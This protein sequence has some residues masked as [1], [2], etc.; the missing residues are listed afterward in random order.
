M[1]KGM[2]DKLKVYA[3]DAAMIFLATQFTVVAKADRNAKN[4][5]GV[6]ETMQ[7]CNLYSNS[8]KSTEMLIEKIEE[9]AKAAGISQEEKQILLKI[10]MAEAEGEGT[11]G[12]AY[13]MR[14]VLN[15][16][17]SEEFPNTIKKVVFQKN[18]F[19]PVK[20][21]GRYWN[22]EPDEEC[23]E[24]YNMI[25]NGWDDSEGALYFSRTGSSP[26]MQENTDFLY[27]IG[28]HSFY[29]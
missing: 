4:D 28:N 12:K 16:V 10:A 13:V 20:D 27:E 17:Q 22:L 23:Y 8:S 6:Y 9:K 5:I 21:N 18:Q 24:A 25:E 26:W 29:K 1:R 14:V 11:S 2:K 15:R 19:S 3:V 7:E